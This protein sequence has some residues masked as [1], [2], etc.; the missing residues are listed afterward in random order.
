M[1]MQMVAM[2]MESPTSD[3]SHLEGLIVVDDSDTFTIAK[4]KAELEK[5]KNDKII[6][7]SAVQISQ[8]LQ[9]LSALNLRVLGMM[10]VEIR[11]D[12]TC[13][14]GLVDLSKSGDSMVADKGF[15]IKNLLEAKGVGLNILPS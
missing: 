11:P 14:S 15:T 1:M 10:L 3:L 8:L 7:A 13:L 9:R 5:K 4:L 6:V 12:I 2:T